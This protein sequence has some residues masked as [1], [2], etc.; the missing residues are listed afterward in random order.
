MSRSDEAYC[1]V[2]GGGGAKGIFHVGAWQALREMDVPVNAFIG[3][4]IGAIIAGYLA[5]GSET[6][7]EEIASRIGI[8]YILKVPSELVQ[9]GEFKV[10]RASLRH[11]RKLTRDAWSHKGLSTEPLRERLMNDIDEKRLRSSGNDLGVVTFNVSEM[12]PREVFI[13]E[14]EPGTV[15]DYLLASSAV[16]G[17]QMPKIG[18]ERYLDGGVYDNIPYAMARRRGYRRLIVVDI[19]GIGVT[20]RPTI[21]GTETIYIKNSI[22]MGGIL[23]FDKAFLDRFRLLGYLDTL[24]TFGR[25]DGRS[26]FVEPNAEA[27]RRFLDLITG[28]QA[29]SALAE[30]MASVRNEEDIQP[31]WSLRLLLPQPMRHERRLL[32]SVMECAALILGVERIARYTYHDLLEQ[33]AGRK[34]A[35]DR[36][37]AWVMRSTG[38]GESKRR[39][40]WIRAIVRRS[41]RMKRYGRPPYYYNQIFSHFGRSSVG[42]KRPPR[43][44]RRAIAALSHEMPAGLL[45]LE[46]LPQ[47][48]KLLR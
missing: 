47:V 28:E 21:V 10:T 4:S 27:E 23:D 24:R 44:L 45:L 15:A 38:G 40:R 42:P 16:P 34:S 46:M 9:N 7:M 19:S 20:R 32:L 8:D 17:F 33:I 36:R 13:E 22:N 48:R 41:V 3:N 1:L 29:A 11:L 37:V 25:L 31:P 12:H 30:T 18:G 6:E 43:L 35:I 14:M 5:Q 2:L 26:Y 39:L